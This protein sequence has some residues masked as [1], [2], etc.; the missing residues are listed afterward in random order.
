MGVVESHPVYE[1]ATAETGKL[2]LE[3]LTDMLPD[4]GDVA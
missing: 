4:V 1:A 3:K 2:L